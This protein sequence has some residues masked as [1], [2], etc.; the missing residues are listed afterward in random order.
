M[1]MT[2]GVIVATVSSTFVL[3]Y[4]LFG[5]RGFKEKSC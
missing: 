5:V 4:S 2:L 3:I 1:A